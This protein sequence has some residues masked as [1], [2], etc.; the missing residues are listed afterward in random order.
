[1]GNLAWDR[2]TAE[3]HE[4][5]RQRSLDRFDRRL[6]DPPKQL[7]MFVRLG[8]LLMIALAFALAAQLL[9]QLPLH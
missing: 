1:M 5:P 9:V 4:H 8:V 2:L 6:V 3:R 7:D